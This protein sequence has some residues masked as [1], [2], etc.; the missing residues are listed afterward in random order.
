MERNLLDDSFFT[1]T[2]NSFLTIGRKRS[3]ATPSVVSDTKNTSTLSL[4]PLD[5]DHIRDMNEVRLG[6]LTATFEG[7]VRENH[8]SSDDVCHPSIAPIFAH[9]TLF[10]SLQECL[11]F[12]IIYN[13]YRDE[14]HLMVD[15]PSL[16]EHW[17]EGLQHLIGTHSKK[18]QRHLINDQK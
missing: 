18:R 10:L 1:N 7:L 14:L 3:P 2:K 16:R 9:S 13:N 17:V 11:A 12:S 8:L 5:L 6:F 15:D 4:S